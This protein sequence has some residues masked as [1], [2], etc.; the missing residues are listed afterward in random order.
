M[1]LYQ[2]FKP[3]THY[4]SYIITIHQNA[5]ISTPYVYY[6]YIIDVELD[7]FRRI[8]INLRAIVRS[9]RS[10]LRSILYD[11]QLYFFDLSNCSYEFWHLPFFHY[12]CH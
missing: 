12:N 9:L 5:F 7:A 1:R 6:M 3:F 11:M 4:T 8:L 2:W 10:C